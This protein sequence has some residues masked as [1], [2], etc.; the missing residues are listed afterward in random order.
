M[1]CLSNRFAW[2]ILL[3]V[4]WLS[5]SCSTP[6][7]QPGT[8]IDPGD[9]PL[10]KPADSRA[11]IVWR[12]LPGPDFQVFYGNPQDSKTCGFGFFIGG[13]PNFHPA[14]NAVVEIGALGA[15]DVDWFEWVDPYPP[16]YHREAVFEYRPRS[17]RAGYTDRIHVWIYGSTARQVVEMTQF[18]AGLDLFS[19]RP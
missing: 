12:R 13:F 14:T 2:N 15:F 9:Y 1:Q 11:D 3:V 16:Q 5:L 19:R 6:Q 7:Q 8:R 17:A 4:G 10:L 18:L